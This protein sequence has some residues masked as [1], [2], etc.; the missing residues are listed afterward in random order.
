LGRRGERGRW[1]R[2]EIREEGIRE[3]RERKLGSET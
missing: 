3:K 2:K 1:G